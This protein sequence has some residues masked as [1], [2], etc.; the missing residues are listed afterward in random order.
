GKEDYRIMDHQADSEI[1]GSIADRL[2]SLF[3]IRSWSFDKGFY[4][5]NNKSLLE[6]EIEKVIMPKKGK[7][8]NQEKEDENKKYKL[9][10]SA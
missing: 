1:V 6:K 9:K 2:L 10:Q 5:K 4:N 7:C 3:K 8:N